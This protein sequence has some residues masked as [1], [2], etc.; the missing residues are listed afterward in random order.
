MELF[1]RI[2]H[3]GVLIGIFIIASSLARFSHAEWQV[4]TALGLQGNTNA[5]NTQPKQAETMVFGELGVRQQEQSGAFR[6]NI[7]Y[8]FRRNIF[9]EKTNQDRTEH[10]GNINLNWQATSQLSFALDH[11]AR[12]SVAD[13]RLQDIPDNRRQ[14]NTSSLSGNYQ[15]R[16]DRANTIGLQLSTIYNTEESSNNDSLR[17]GLNTRYQ[18]RH[19]SRWSSSLSLSSNAV[20]FVDLIGRDY[21]AHSLTYELSHI[22][23]RGLINIS[24]GYNTISPEN[25]SSNKGTVLGLLWRHNL[26]NGGNIEARIDK[27]LT[28]SSI[29]LSNASDNTQFTTRNNSS[30][31]QIEEALAASL[32]FNRP[33][34]RQTNFNT[35]LT[36]EHSEQLNTVREDKSIS[37]TAGLSHNFTSQ[38]NGGFA[39]RAIKQE[40]IETNA[41]REEHEA[42]LSLTKAFTP[43][44]STQA[45]LGYS[46]EKRISQQSLPQQE[47]GF[48]TLR[49]N[50]RL[51]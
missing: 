39:V 38:V 30:G 28:D 13:S 43:R 20:E 32:L 49:V 7:D 34:S 42:S 41:S 9:L 22:M 18:R 35:R 14:Q 17:Y 27:R 25:G 5:R 45:R 46:V 44:L 50:Y 48:F 26:S 29:G 19:S 6:R 8:L 40:Q 23:A 36:Y 15:I 21:K 16:I 11:I 1:F 47:D 33:L 31:S 10:T 3:Q 37:L 2:N 4:N 24:L 51:L 12:N